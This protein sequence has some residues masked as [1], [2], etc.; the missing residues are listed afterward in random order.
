MSTAPAYGAAPHDAA[1]L[2]QPVPYL[3]GPSA[4]VMD[5]LKLAFGHQEHVIGR[6]PHGLPLNGATGDWRDFGP[7][8]DQILETT[9]VGAQLAYVYPRLADLADAHHDGDFAAQLR[10]AAASLRVAL[11]HEWTGKGWYSRG[12]AG[13][14]QIGSDVIYGETQPWAILAGIPT[15]EQRSTLVANIRRYLT[16]IGA[17]GGPSTIGSALQPA[18]SDCGGA[19]LTEQALGAV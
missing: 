13:P 12:Y 2:D 10:T 1:F 3:D 18:P 15:A 8:S 9:L 7:V 11:Q 16:G 4:T 5:H 19:S 14:H 6:G 17:A